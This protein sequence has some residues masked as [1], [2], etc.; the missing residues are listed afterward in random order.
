MPGG[1]IEIASMD[2][3]VGP[4][5]YYERPL[6]SGNDRPVFAKSR[7]CIGCH[8]G[9]AANFMPGLLGRSVYPTAGRACAEGY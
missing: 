3:L 5:F 1:R 8:A 7:R 9:S 2:P 4:V 6:D